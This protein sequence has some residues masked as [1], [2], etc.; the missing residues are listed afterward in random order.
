[1]NKNNFIEKFQNK[2]DSELEYILENKKSYDEKA[3][4]ASIDI[5]KE[6]NGKSPETETVDNEIQKEKHI[7]QEINK[8]INSE[9]QAELPL[10]ISR[11]AKLIYL[12]LGFGLAS[13]IILE[14]FTDSHNLTNPK[15]LINLILSVGINFFI[16]YNINLGKKWART[17]SLILFVLFVII[18]IFYHLFFIEFFK[19]NPIT[20]IIST[21]S[22]GLH[23]Y[24]LI[25]LFKPDSNE[26]YLKQSEFDI[27]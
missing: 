9:L 8:N 12:S 16:A 10:T 18:I 13:S 20:G 2:T 26:W 19:Q 21:I 4:S 27:K 23:I 22:I 7:T 14:I 6:R 25:L 5:L 1:M 11:A 3:V 15:N 24:S 17:I